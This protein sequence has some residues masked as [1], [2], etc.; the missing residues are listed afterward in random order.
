MRIHA[1]NEITAPV[2]TSLFG[3][4]IDRRG[5]H[6]CLRSDRLAEAGSTDT[7]G[8]DCDDAHAKAPAETRPFAGSARPFAPRSA[9]QLSGQQGQSQTEPGRGPNETPPFSRSQ[10][11]TNGAPSCWWA[12]ISRSL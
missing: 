2:V 8:Q 7:G 4:L 5:W 6:G 12:A 10:T 3:T 11:S 9:H 1:Q